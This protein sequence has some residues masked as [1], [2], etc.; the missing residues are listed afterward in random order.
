[1]ISIAKISENEGVMDFS[2]KSG[3]AI[4]IQFSTSEPIVSNI[5]NSGSDTEKTMF[6]NKLFYRIPALAN[7]KIM[8]GN[9]VLAEYY[10]KISQFGE[11]L[12]I[13]IN[14]HGIVFNPNT[15]QVVR[16]KK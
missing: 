8:C 16:I 1:M 6:N 5:A 15:G 10:L 7:A 13:P 14:G 11:T 3:N 2:A 9:D 4:K 12:T